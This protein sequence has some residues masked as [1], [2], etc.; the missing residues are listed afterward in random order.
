VSRFAD[1]ALGTSARKVVDLP[2]PNGTSDRVAVRV[3]ND[4]DDSRVDDAALAYA[5]DHGVAEELAKPEHPIY[6]RGHALNTLLLGCSDPDSPDDAPV[7]Y[8]A[9]V[10]EIQAG[11]DRDR[12]A[13]LLAAQAIH[14][15][16]CSSR[17]LTMAGD[18]VF[19]TLL[20]VATSEDARPFL[21]LHPGYAWILLRSTASLVCS[22]PDLS[23]SYTS[24]VVLTSNGLRAKASN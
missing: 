16:Q 14:Q 7:P 13:I 21:R 12:I 10:T 5:K 3:F 17:K 9:S 19:A 4:I 24:Q 20:D 23:S 22:S 1:I 18:E 2:L 11:L 8:F 6:D 15:E